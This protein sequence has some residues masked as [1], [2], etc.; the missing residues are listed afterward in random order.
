MEGQVICNQVRRE[1]SKPKITIMS[2]GGG[3]SLDG[4]TEETK[5]EVD[6]E[7]MREGL[8]RASA[9]MFSGPGT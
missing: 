8:E 9:T 3:E 7:D 1:M 2:K 4:G 5:A 6:E